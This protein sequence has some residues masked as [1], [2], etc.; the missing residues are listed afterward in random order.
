MREEV[1]SAWVRSGRACFYVSVSFRGVGVGL[2]GGFCYVWGLR[3]GFLFVEKVSVIEARYNKL[4][5]KYSEFI[6][7]YVELFRKVGF[8]LVLCR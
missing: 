8:R 4:K 7:T 2:L 6:N 1:E 3:F 5:E